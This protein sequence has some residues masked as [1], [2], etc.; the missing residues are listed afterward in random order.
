MSYEHWTVDF[1]YVEHS[2][3]IIAK[4][5]GGISRGRDA[6]SAIPASCDAINVILGSQ[7]G[8][9]IIKNMSRVS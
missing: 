5:I 3:Y 2:E 9:E 6:G 1:K 7:F 8:G 4:P